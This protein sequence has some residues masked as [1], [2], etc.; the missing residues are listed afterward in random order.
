MGEG[1]LRGGRGARFRRGGGARRVIACDLDPDA[2][3]ASEA[4]AALNG[5]SLELSDDL[6]ACL[7]LADRVT[8]ADILYDRDNLP[9]LARFR[10]AGAPVLLADSRIAGL[11]PPGYRPLGNWHATTWPDLGEASEFN[12]VRLFLSE[13]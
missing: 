9:L 1:L 13:P 2:L 3:A 6:D 4:N 7:A 11:Q 8:A 5:V 10:R 12:Q